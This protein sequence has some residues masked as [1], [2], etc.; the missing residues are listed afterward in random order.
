MAG[1]APP[2]SAATNLV[3]DARQQVLQALGLRVPRDDVR[4]GR[5]GGLDWPHN[6]KWDIEIANLA[7]HTGKR[8]GSPFG[9]L[10]WM[11]LPLSCAARA[12]SQKAAG[13]QQRD[14][15]CHCRT[16][17]RLTSSIPGIVLTPSRFR[18][19]WSRLSSIGRRQQREL[20]LGGRGTRN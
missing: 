16:L 11:T 12:A 8:A 17:K 3:Q 5:D 20:G 1:A 19:F 6:S 10:K 7:G 2:N 15:R 4:V 9:L 13:Q 14:H 18:V